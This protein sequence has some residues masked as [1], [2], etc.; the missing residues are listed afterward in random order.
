MALILAACGGGSDP[1]PT[2]ALAS[3]PTPTASAPSIRATPTPTSVPDVAP[4]STPTA[5]PPPDVSRLGQLDVRVMDAPNK[6]V[7]EI[8][9]TVTQIQVHRAGAAD[10]VWTTVLEGEH[11]FDLLKVIGRESSLGIGDLEPGMYTQ[12]R[13]TVTEVLVT[14]G[15][16]QMAAVLPSSVLRLV[17]TIEVVAGETTILTFDFDAERSIISAG[18]GK[19]FRPTVR[20]FVRKEGEELVREVPVAEVPTESGESDT[21]NFV[22]IEATKDTSIYESHT[23]NSNGRGA[24][25]LVG[26]NSQNSARRSLLQFPVISFLPRDSVI[27]GVTLILNVSD[28]PTRAT[29]VAFH[30]VS[31]DWGEGTADG[32]DDEDRGAAASGADATWSFGSY[33]DVRWANPGG[34]FESVSS[35][36]LSVTEEGLITWEAPPQMIADVQ[37]WLENPQNNFGW[38]L[39]GDEENPMTLVRF[40]TT[41]N[42]DGSV[43]PQL[44]VT[45]GPGG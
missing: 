12:A 4:T 8:L 40:N 23:S 38:L 43:R 7:T 37:D 31:V 22:T 35:G 34:D 26:N 20:L 11:Q 18:P 36:S 16:Q 32:A 24:F 44:V 15:G 13:L 17:G 33:L 28:A 19:I 9:M 3:T 14:D 45:F 29:T 39:K 27:T 6:A 42:S 2:P 1:T 41:E 30:K 21:G 10:D 25:L 5:T